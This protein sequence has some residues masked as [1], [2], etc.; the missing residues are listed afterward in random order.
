M[1]VSLASDSLVDS[2]GLNWLNSDLIYTVL[3][4]LDRSMKVTFVEVEATNHAE[5]IS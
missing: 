3:A 1:L 4:R 5:S 2:S